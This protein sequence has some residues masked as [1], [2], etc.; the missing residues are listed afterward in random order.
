MPLE[1]E[2]DYQNLYFEETA[3]VPHTPLPP[4]PGLCHIEQITMQ[5]SGD[6]LQIYTAAGRELLP[7]YFLFF[8]FS[9]S[10][11]LPIPSTHAIN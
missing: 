8:F 2:W 11:P 3:G 9:S 5:T 7:K 1:L 6:L 4:M 10:P